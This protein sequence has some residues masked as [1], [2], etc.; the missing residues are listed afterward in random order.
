[1]AWNDAETAPRPTEFSPVAYGDEAGRRLAE[2][3]ALDQRAEAIA[4]RLPA[5]KRDGFHHLVLY[6]RLWVSIDWKKLKRGETATGTVTVSAAGARR[7]IAI[8]ARNVAAP[9]GALMEDNGIVAFSADRYTRLQPGAK[10]GGWQR[11]PDLGLSRRA[12]S[13]GVELPSIADPTTAPYAEYRFRSTSI[14]AAKLRAT[15]LPSFALS[16]EHKLRYAVSVDGSPIQIVDADKG[17]NWGGGVQCNG[18]TS[19]ADWTIARPGEHRLRIYAIE[20]GGVLDT[21]V[22]DRQTRQR[23][24]RAAGDDRAIGGDTVTLRYT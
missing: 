17:R 6:Q 4:A 9:A 18:I 14:G 16:A 3:R 23:L 5:D 21:L 10:T 19:V 1:M 8:E 22:V 7:S 24:S 20:P 11:I 15:L 12:I 2:F 13:T